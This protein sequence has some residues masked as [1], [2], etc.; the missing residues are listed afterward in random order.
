ML[1][2]MRRN[3]KSLIIWIIFGIIIAAFIISFGPQSG[4]A[5]G[6]GSSAEHALDVGDREVS[7]GS[8][9]FVTNAMPQFASPAQR[10]PYVLDALIERELLARVAEERGF[11]VS[12]EVV[13]KAIAAGT[14]YVG[15]I[16][17]DGKRQYY[18]DGAFDV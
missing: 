15:G 7:L 12:D 18:K 1:E 13:N 14:I 11:K 16:R 4:Q 5:Q 17:R 10:R 9:R 6:C 3:S 2:T 8:W